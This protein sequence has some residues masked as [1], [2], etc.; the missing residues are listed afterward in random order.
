MLQMFSFLVL[1][2]RIWQHTVCWFMV[3]KK[4]VL[5]NSKWGANITCSFLT[6][7]SF[8]IW[9]VCTVKKKIR[10]DEKFWETATD[11][12]LHV[13]NGL[14][15]TGLCSMIWKYNNIFIS[16]AIYCLFSANYYYIWLIWLL[17]VIFSLF[18]SIC[19]SYAE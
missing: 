13:I 7:L 9:F 19:D 12:S 10:H 6:L 1:F 11:I 14:D 3:R 5:D 15:W 16:R 18:V 8:P 2:W 17:D 4:S